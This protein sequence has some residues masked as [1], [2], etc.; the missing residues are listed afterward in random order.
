V[1]RPL[2]EDREPPALVRRL[3]RMLLPAEEREFYLGDLRESG[4]RSW[5]RELAGAA[6]LRF[7]RRRRGW[8]VAGTGKAAYR[9]SEIATD[10]RHGFRRMARTP[11]A[12]LTVLT[13]LSVG[14][15]LSGLMFSLI[16]SAL[17]P[18]LPFEAGDRIVR[19]Q[20][21]GF[22]PLSPEAVDWWRVRQRSFEGL[23]GWVERPVNLAVEGDRSEL[24]YSAAADAA[25]L[26]LLS[27]QPVLGRGFTEADAAP[28]AS[29]VVLIGHDTWRTRLNA[30]AE[31][32]GRTVRVNSEPAE[33][34]GV[35]PEG[36]GFPWRQEL[37]TPLRLDPL[38]SDRNPA[39]VWAFG[40]LRAGVSSE[41]AAA[42]LNDLDR[43]RPRPVGEPDAA[44]AEVV[45]FTDII[46][47]RGMSHVLAAIM[48][49]VALLVLLVACANATNVLLAQ[50]VARGRE[51]AIRTSL[52]AS[53][54][55]IALQ[56][57]IELASLAIAA[58]AG[59]AA[60]AAVGVRLVERAVPAD[61]GMPFWFDLRVD[62]SALVFIAGAAVV[63]VLL[64]GVAP[65]LHASRAN[66]SGLLAD[67]SRG[68]SSRR[69]GRVMGRLIGAEMAVSLVLLVAAGLCV[70]SAVNLRT[71]DFAFDPE[72][73]YTSNV[74]LPDGRYDDA[75]DR[76]A[77]VAQLEQRL[78]A[79]PGASS[80]AFTTNVPG[81]EAPRGPVAVE[82]VHDPADADLPRALHVAVSPAFF[83][84]FRG[85]VLAGR[86]FDARDGPDALPV[87][88][89]NHAFE[90]TFLPDGAVGHR[91][92]LPTPEGRTEWLTVVGVAPDLMAGGLEREL[93]EAVYRPLAQDVPASF[94]LAVRSSIAPTA[95][96][97]P[98]REAVAAVDPDV[99]L[100]FGGPLDAAID[101][102]NS[103]FAWLSALF[104]L[105]GLIALFLAAIGL[106]G[107]MA[108]WV[109]QRTREIGVRMALGG[110]RRAIVG[111][112]LRQAMTQIAAG[113]VVGLAA[114]AAVA[115]LLHGVLLDVAPW[116][117]LVFGPVL[118]VL[119]AA[120]WLGCA[121]P[122][123]RATRVNPQSALAAE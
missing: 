49:S 108:F 36:Y 35:M 73:V 111:L 63:A 59:G 99:V 47:P 79:I 37:W 92:A 115:W 61:S 109:A 6:T 56:V 90:R 75:A 7:S 96:A 8:A 20:R 3:L 113:L 48:L 76:A 39:S 21:A 38:R 40:V 105:A 34:I 16:D 14:I 83:G 89:V 110:G 32:V 121:L 44:P 106:Y 62:V 1:N 4:R 66:G 112:V 70:R 65:A 51:V 114:A 123:L 22:A 33:V 15:G 78:A 116:D 46:N 53:R 67:A 45:A 107:V 42:E 23:A 41:A 95:L 74:R 27:V 18:T 119:L 54:V 91:I 30:D 29:A 26:H 55:R 101:A 88:I 13:A 71:Y 60:L 122:A 81:I 50:A 102:A 72:G 93:E 117:P 118:V 19:V 2:G 86:A 58:T 69:V 25:T 98:V 5:L 77:L 57:W 12:T 94:V 97:Q 103:A 82:A 68:T 64:A 104:L 31:V 17:L 87:A 80:V 85:G 24:V 52:G 9:L 11:A 100:H 43:Q 10:A 120:A 28:G 84:T